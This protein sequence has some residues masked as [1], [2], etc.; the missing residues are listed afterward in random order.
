VK[1]K[2]NIDYCFNNK[3]AGN[4]LDIESYNST[5]EKCNEIS[6]DLQNQ[7]NNGELQLFNPDCYNN[8]SDE[9]LSVVDNIKANFKNL[10]VLGTG[11]STL[12]G[13]VLTG[14]SEYHSIHSD[15][16]DVHFIENVDPDIFLSTLDNLELKDTYFLVVSKS[17]STLETISQF[18]VALSYISNEYG[19]DRIKDHFCCISD[20]IASPLR[21][22]AD[23]YSI[24]VLEHERKIGGRFSLLTNVGLIPG[25][26]AGIDANKLLKSA[27]SAIEKSLSKDSEAMKGAAINYEFMKK[28]INIAVTLSY[29]DRL[30]N[31]AVWQRQIWSESLGKEGKG[32][33]PINSSGTLDQ[34]SQLQLYLDGPDDKFFTVILLENYQKD[35]KFDEDFLHDE[36]LAYIRNHNFS[37]VIKVSSIA[38]RD[39]LI[40]NNK[41][42]RSIEINRLD[43]EILG[44]LIIQSIFET[45]YTASLLRLNAFD[46]PAVEEGKI[47]AK[48]LLSS[49]S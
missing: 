19:K 14:F 45:V 32:S 8:I 21:R 34:H 35:F 25:L 4:A 24:R 10:L 17:G 16:T 41:P 28:D 7:I 23:E 40:A 11:G 43:E 31:F 18:V 38:T 49:L 27:V 44:E 47:L 29:V 48:K 26:V 1:Y 37:E 20:D 46:Q 13:Q 9:M 36:D 33:T 39:T 12:C 30:K 2:H 22:L 42:T 3:I 15:K 6:I 5:L